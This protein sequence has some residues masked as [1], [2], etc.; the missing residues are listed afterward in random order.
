MGVVGGAGTGSPKQSEG[1]GVV[2]PE[3][4]WGLRV[5]AVIAAAAVPRTPVWVQARGL[6]AL[7]AVE[8]GAA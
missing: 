4:C 2:D 5:E 8:V 7:L 6:L 1:R 3:S